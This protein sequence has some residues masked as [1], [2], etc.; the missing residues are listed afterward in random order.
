MTFI[1]GQSGNPG[2][3]PKESNEAKEL[4]KKY[5]P[6]AFKRLVYWM[7]SD[8][9]RASISAAQTIIERAYG[10]VPQAIVGDQ[11]SPLT[12]RFVLEGLPAEN[13]PLMIDAVAES[14][15]TR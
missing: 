2:G 3:R 11:S 15:E 1:K 6:E 12:V 14:S 4:A 7:K 8:E 13:A 10:K 9:A 5:G